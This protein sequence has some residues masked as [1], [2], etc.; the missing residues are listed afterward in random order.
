MV[1]ERVAPLFSTGILTVLLQQMVGMPVVGRAFVLLLNVIPGTV[2]EI[3]GEGG[4]V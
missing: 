2:W 4:H 3:E 1:G